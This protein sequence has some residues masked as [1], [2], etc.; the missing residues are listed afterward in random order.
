MLWSIYTPQYYSSSWVVPYIPAQ[1]AQRR[2]SI[3]SAPPTP[4]ASTP[5]RRSGGN[6]GC[7]RHAS[8]IALAGKPSTTHRRSRCFR[9]IHT[10]FR[11]FLRP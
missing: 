1:T 5:L 7:Q 4:A 8:G 11:E 10:I 6:S 3:S 9:V 2:F